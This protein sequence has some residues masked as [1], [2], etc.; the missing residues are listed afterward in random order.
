M[1]TRKKSSARKSSRRKSSKSRAKKSS[2]RKK[3]ARKSTARK[4][5]ARKSAAR[6][7]TARKSTRRK[8]KKRRTGA[9][10]APN[11]A[12]M[13]PMSPSSELA[14]VVGSSPMPRTEVTKRLW[15]YIKRRGLQDDKN[16]RMINADDNLRPIF[17]GRR[18]V[19]MFDMTRMVN[20][21]LS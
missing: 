8:A 1:A 16:R 17:G 4:K 20:Q 9:K 18:Q 5:T 7:K 11:P 3:T 14:A 15:S 21:H 12:F 2:A 10:R 19:S 13:K 6:K